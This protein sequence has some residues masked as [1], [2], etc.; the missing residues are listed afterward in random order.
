MHEAVKQA[1]GIEIAN[2]E[3]CMWLGDGGDGLEYNSSFPICENSKRK[4]AD[5]LKSFP[6][7]A[8]QKC[9]VPHFWISKF[10]AMIKHGEDEE[11]L[12]MIKEFRVAVE[13]AEKEV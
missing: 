2:C 13:A 1:T 6:F 11:V 9:W 4:G 7:K 5:N 12:N 3:T 8:E 10:P